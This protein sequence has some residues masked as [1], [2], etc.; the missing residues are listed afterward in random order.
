MI[1]G[2]M[3]SIITTVTASLTAVAVDDIVIIPVAVGVS[4]N[5]VTGQCVMLRLRLL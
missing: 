1:A 2:I 3:N 4:V 5:L